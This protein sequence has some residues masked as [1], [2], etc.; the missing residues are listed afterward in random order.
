VHFTA[1]SF[2]PYAEH[3]LLCSQAKE[4][5][6]HPYFADLDKELVDQLE[7]PAIAERDE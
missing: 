4:A 3:A 2:V 7:N 6:K 5:M 1:S